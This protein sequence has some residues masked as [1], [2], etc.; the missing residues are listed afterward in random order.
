[1]IWGIV[2]TSLLVGIAFIVWITI[3]S[4]SW[5]AGF[6]LSSKTYSLIVA[7]LGV[8][9]F[10]IISLVIGLIYLLLVDAKSTLLIVTLLL[11]PGIIIFAFFAQIAYHTVT[12]KRR[13]KYENQLRK[14]V[15]DWMKSFQVIR[16]QS[17]FTGGHYVLKVFASPAEVVKMKQKESDLN[18][19]VVHYFE[20]NR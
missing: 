4:N 17:Y 14:Q 11:V 3:V 16:S 20:V 2:Q 7:Q 5:K 13:D 19:V 8:V 10:S 9:T 12:K 18:G 6:P 15:S 1:M